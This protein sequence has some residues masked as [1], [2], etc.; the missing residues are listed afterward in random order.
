MRPR[1]SR[2]PTLRQ[3]AAMVVVSAG[4]V[5]LTAPAPALAA[6]SHAAGQGAVV[7]LTDAVIISVGSLAL[8]IAGIW[9]HRATARI[10]RYVPRVA[11]VPRDGR[12][13]PV[14]GDSASAPA[15]ARRGG[16]RVA[17]GPQLRTATKPT[18]AIVAPPPPHT[19]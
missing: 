15:P 12:P 1:A 4:G 18:P 17:A 10:V 3:K 14:P 5:I 7:S 13:A 2:S 9:F 19:R 6:G 8:L 11:A 16:H